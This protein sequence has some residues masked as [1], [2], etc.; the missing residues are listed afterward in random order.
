MGLQGQPLERRSWVEETARNHRGWQGDFQ[1]EET[2]GKREAMAMSAGRWA[3][4]LGG[5]PTRH[6][7]KKSILGWGGGGRRQAGLEL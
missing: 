6:F 2:M 7:L 4:Q 5:V 1:D 3:V